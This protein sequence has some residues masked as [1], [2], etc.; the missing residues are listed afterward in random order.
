MQ[1]VLI[2]RLMLFCL[3]ISQIDSEALIRDRSLQNPAALDDLIR[4]IT[5][6]GLR[7]PIEVFGLTPH[8][9]NPSLYGLI[10]GHR[11]LRAFV[12]MG[13]T[14]IPAILCNPADIP[15]AMAAMIS[16]NENRS[17]I[18]PWEK[19]RLI[20]SLIEDGQYTDPDLAIDALY[21]SA[22]R[23]QRTRIRNCHMVFAAFNYFI[24]TPERLTTQQIDRLAMALRLGAED[25]LMQTLKADFQ[26]ASNFE[27]QWSALR[28]VLNAVFS[29]EPD[30]GPTEEKERR[31]PRHSMSTH[32]G[33]FRLTREKTRTGWIIRFSGPMAQSPGLVD[34]V[35][36][37]V[38]F[39]LGPRP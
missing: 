26:H 13:R 21:P 25:V 10:S 23:Q 15:A 39:W 11:R 16:E 30:Y 12:A 5:E 36:D 19:G 1:R 7:Q 14:E 8:A 35:F 37:L 29:E 38:E 27:S 3:W 28:P 31:A 18:T 17:Q 32:G 4:S 2:C 22:T 34:K 9:H 6:I 20:Q 33:D 24:V